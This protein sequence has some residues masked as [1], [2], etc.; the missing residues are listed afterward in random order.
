ML[1][2]RALERRGKKLWKK[3]R[4]DYR[5][6]GER[7]PTFCP[8]D[9]WEDKGKRLV[10]FGECGKNFFLFLPQFLHPYFPTLLHESSRTGERSL[11]FFSSLEND[12]QMRDK[13]SLPSTRSQHDAHGAHP[14][15]YLA[16]SSP[17]LHLSKVFRLDER[18]ERERE[19]CGTIIFPR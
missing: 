17:T 16:R 9:P 8:R 12:P 13:F 6:G 19:I 2:K 3:R 10:S 1:S 4:N 18:G 11:F 15:E 7:G 14:L 5:I